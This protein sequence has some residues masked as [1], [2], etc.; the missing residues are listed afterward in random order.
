MS[1]DKQSIDWYNQNAASYT[2]HVRNPNDS[3][4]HT[5]Y[6]KPAMYSLLPELT[7]KSVISLGCGSGED[8][9]YL[10]QQGASRSVG[11]DISEKLI[12]IAQHD[13]PSCEFSVSDMQELA[14]DDNTFDFAYSSLAI[15]YLQDWTQVFKETYRILK[16]DSY[17]LFSCAHPIWSA[18]ETTE[19]TED[20][21]V[22]QLAFIK[23]RKGNSVAV[24]GDYLTTRP[25]TSNSGDMAVTT[26]HKPISEILREI[27]LSGFQIDTFVEPLPV[28]E[29]QEH[30][31]V[32]YERLSKVPYVM[33]FRL[34][35]QR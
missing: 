23:N 31:S 16:P 5:F 11:V 33:I 30:D 7:N 21:K 9:N 12:A 20:Q 34:H 18:M 3:L 13:Y 14:F 32:E 6:E 35:K 25:L 1:T 27:K 8:S 19:D 28:E 10:K 24:I 17:F 2:A 15:H 22:K 26:W 4:Y 29:M